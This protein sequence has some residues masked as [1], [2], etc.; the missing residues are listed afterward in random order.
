MIV[1]TVSKYGKGRHNKNLTSVNGSYLLS[2]GILI[3]TLNTTEVDLS[4]PG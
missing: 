2:P 4:C 1:T 3:S